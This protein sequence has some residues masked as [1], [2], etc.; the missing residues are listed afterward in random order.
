MAKTVKIASVHISLATYIKAR[1][2]NALH[3]LLVGCGFGQL[4]WLKES[5]NYPKNATTSN[6]QMDSS[7]HVS[8][9]TVYK[10]VWLYRDPAKVKRFLSLRFFFGGLLQTPWRRAGAL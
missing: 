1:K 4:K 9:L 7:G 5:E 6:V 10:Y 2:Y 3:I 8:I